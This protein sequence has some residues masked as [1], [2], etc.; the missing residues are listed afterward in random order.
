MPICILDEGPRMDEGDPP[1]IYQPQH[2]HFTDINRFNR[3][4][5]PSHPLQ[6]DSAWYLKS[7][8]KAFVNISHAAKN[9]D[10][11]TL[12][13][14]FK[15]G[16][17]VDIRDKY[18]KTP[19]MLAASKG[20]VKTC[21]FLISCGADI[22]AFDNFKWTA[23]HHSC[24][25]GQLD[26]VKLLVEAGA[27]VNALTLTQGTPFM[28]AVESA[29]YPVVEYLM[30]KG[31]KISQEN[32]K[33]KTVLDIAKDFA[34]PR[35]FLTVKNKME[36]IPKPKEGKGKEK[37]KGKKKPAAAKKKKSDTEESKKDAFLPPISM[38]RR[39]YS[40]TEA[41]FAKDLETERILFRPIHVWTEQDT[42][43]QLLE[44]K[45]MTRDQY[46]WEIDFDDYKL[47]FL[48]NLNKK[49][50]KMAQA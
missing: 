23:L 15:R 41:L 49:V 45:K 16:L 26:V 37:G 22:H 11:N 50:E 12:L 7:P 21:N 4:K 47:P 10:L 30:E 19:L 18:Y 32:I 43:E 34:D 29:S 17:P 24:H 36:G 27:D 13:D 2:I 48:K 1:A 42:T 8:D 28:R 35:I 3:D 31:A 40:T 44:K 14:A 38:K 9:G 39:S 5:P 20:D 6:D 33:G 25:T 46:G